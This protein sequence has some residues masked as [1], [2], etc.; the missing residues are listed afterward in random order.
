MAILISTQTIHASIASVIK[1]IDENA[2]IY[3]NPNQQGTVYPAWFIVHR[4]PVEVRRD[5]GRINKGNRYEVTYQIDIVYMI[6]QNIPRMFDQYI[7]IAEQLDSKLEYLPIFGTDTVIHVYDRTWNL[8]MNAMRYSATLRIRCFVDS[9]YVP[10]PME[11]SPDVQ[12][13]IKE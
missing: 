4:S 3:D 11:G 6:Q 1:S 9:E 12:T 10:E 5:F 7:Q 8:E 13:F 2:N